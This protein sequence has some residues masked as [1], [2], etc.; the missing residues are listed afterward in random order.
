M[1]YPNR[2]PRFD[3]ADES[4]WLVVQRDTRA[5][6]FEL[7]ACGNRCVT[8]GSADTSD[9]RI[10]GAAPIAFHVERDST[11]VWLIPDYAKGDVHV[12]TQCLN[13]KRQVFGNAVA[14]I[15]GIRIVLQIRDTPPTLRGDI[16]DHERASS[17]SDPIGPSGSPAISENAVTALVD[18]REL[19]PSL[20]QTALGNGSRDELL[21][22]GEACQTVEM[23]AMNFDE[24]FDRAIAPATQGQ[25]DTQPFGPPVVGITPASTAVPPLAVELPQAL[26]ARAEVQLG[27]T[28]TLNTDDIRK[29]LDEAPSAIVASTSAEVAPAG[30]LHVPVRYEPIEPQPTIELPAIRLTDLPERRQSQ[31]PI[32]SSPAGVTRTQ[33]PRGES[34]ETTQFDATELKKAVA[35]RTNPVASAMVD[36]LRLP[37]ASEWQGLPGMALTLATSEVRS[38]DTGPPVSI[39]DS[40]ER[41]PKF[42]AQLGVLTTRHPLGVLGGAALG[43][44]V[45]IVFLVGAAHLFRSHSVKTSNLSAQSHHVAVSSWSATQYASEAQNKV[46]ERI[47][48]L[49]DPAGAASE[50]AP[51]NAVVQAMAP[52]ANATIAVGHL[53]AGRLAEAEQ[54]YRELAQ[55]NPD[56]ATYPVLARILT[57][58]NR[59]ECRATGTAKNLCPMVKP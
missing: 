55:H 33:L 30:H 11:G 39:S 43:S 49:I 53:F 8:F 21:L 51:T 35:G 42:L 45:I 22:D 3:V 9:V 32:I 44:L 40:A 38:L 27:R 36:P 56:D 2:H 1:T 15:A 59:A 18:R 41:R 47:A 19:L 24:W 20:P 4:I 12:D 16:R 50:P 23:H 28:E 13:T 6:A 46:P 25:V 58:R 14:E 34:G 57:R 17:P 48:A 10:E 26:S 7:D 54:A 52:D 29:A 31:S 37:N 5:S